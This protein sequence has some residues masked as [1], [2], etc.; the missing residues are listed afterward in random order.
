MRACS[1][2][3][4]LV[5]LTEVVRPS[6]RYA[7]CSDGI[8]LNAILKDPMI[9]LNARSV[10]LQNHHSPP[11][12]TQIQQQLQQIQLRRQHQLLLLQQQQQRQQDPSESPIIT[13]AHKNLHT[14]H[15]SQLDLK[16]NS[17]FHNVSAANGNV[18]RNIVGKNSNREVYEA[19]DTFQANNESV[20]HLK[21]TIANCEDEAFV[22]TPPLQNP[23]KSRKSFMSTPSQIVN[24]NQ[25]ISNIDEDN[26]SQLESPF[27]SLPQA[28]FPFIN[29][30]KE[31]F[32]KHNQI[33][34]R[35]HHAEGDTS[36]SASDTASNFGRLPPS[37]RGSLPLPSPSGE[38]MT[39]TSNFDVPIVTPIK[40]ATFRMNSSKYEDGGI[41]ATPFVHPAA[42]S[43]SATSS[44]NHFT[45]KSAATT[46]TST[47][48]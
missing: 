19:D 24:G 8:Q 45:S 17:L 10:I 20:S 42:Q 48:T 28:A 13:K 35:D 11:I 4:K 46:T 5:V 25:N 14:L 2:F 43:V 3:E 37:C 16:H 30:N 22:S 6:S 36:N 1:T 33:F 27:E 15:N 7:I 29:T 31:E 38:S 18:S 32:T 21:L 12:Q 44:A 23:S 41:S 47:S 34:D 39:T 26:S 9:A 40:N